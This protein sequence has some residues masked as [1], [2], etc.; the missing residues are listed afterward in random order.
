MEIH[1]SIEI[2]LPLICVG[3]VLV[4]LFFFLFFLLRQGRLPAEICFRY[5][6]IFPGPVQETVSEASFD[7][8]TAASFVWRIQ[9]P[10]PPEP[11]HPQTEPPHLDFYPSLNYVYSTQFY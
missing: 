11:P 3:S 10:K 6:V 2:P 7:P 9:L 5:T 8:G 1:I 4:F